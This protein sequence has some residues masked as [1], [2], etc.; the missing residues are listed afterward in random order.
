MIVSLP[1]THM[2]LISVGGART[3][4]AISLGVA[5]AGRPRGL[6]GSVRA[7]ASTTRGYL[8][9][10]GFMA[11]LFGQVTPC[12]A[13]RAGSMLS[14]WLCIP[15]LVDDGDEIDGCRLVAAAAAADAG[16]TKAAARL[17][18]DRWRHRIPVRHHARAIGLIRDHVR[19]LGDHSQTPLR[20]RSGAGCLAQDAGDAD[21][22][23]A[24]N[25]AGDRWCIHRALART[26]VAP[27]PG[28]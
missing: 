19:P 22:K 5:G 21:P 12:S 11:M 3:F 10:T 26:E 4:P 8:S 6:R 15:Q 17:C 28:H 25:L 13:T 23:P 18:S 20:S 9:T 7:W 27:Q 16:H 2:H 14:T 24:C 1:F